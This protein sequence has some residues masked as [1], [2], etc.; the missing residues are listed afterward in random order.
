MTCV[1]ANCT[2]TF[3]SSI[4]FSSP[5]NYA[6]QLVWNF[7]NATGLSFGTMFGGT[8]L[9]PLA[10]VTN[11]NQIDGTLIAAN[12]NGTGELHSYAYT[13]TLPST[14]VPEPPAETMFGAGLMALATLR[15][16]P[17]RPGLERTV[18]IQNGTPARF[19]LVRM[20]CNVCTRLTVANPVSR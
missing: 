10:N 1:A 16:R 12:F 19:R 2:F 6:E 7:I 20:V 17:R 3:G 14:A 8:V 13:G 5:T 9:A 11:S 18:A 15:K 4:N